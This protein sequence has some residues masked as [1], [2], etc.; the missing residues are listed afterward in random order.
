MGKRIS[1]AILVLLFLTLSQAAVI[2]IDFGS[3]YFKTQIVKPGSPFVIVENTASQRKTPSAVTFTSEER[4]FGSDSIMQSSSNPTNTFTFNRDMIGLTYSEETVKA[5]RNEQYHFNEF[6]S[7]ERGLIGFKI[8]SKGD[9]D[10]ET[11][12]NEEIL[13]NIFYHA[14]YL[15]YQQ[16]KSAIK[17][18]VLTVPTYFDM[19]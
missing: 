6:V 14:F 19:N 17:E 4:V 16:G 18:V 15:S 11:F 13:A 10:H 9:K 7:D 1:K 8:E 12:T 3:E 5:L 2:G